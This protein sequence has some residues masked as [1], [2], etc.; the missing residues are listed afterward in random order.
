MAEEDVV[1]LAHAAR[2]FLRERAC[3]SVSCAWRLLVGSKKWALRAQQHPH[4]CVF[5]N[6][7]SNNQRTQLK[8]DP[9]R[10]HHRNMDEQAPVDFPAPQASERGYKL[11][12]VPLLGSSK[13]EYC[14]RNHG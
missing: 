13:S 8:T 1:P 2:D 3:P 9:S 4:T 14:C 6:P 12:G 7:H 10:C 5:P 11:C